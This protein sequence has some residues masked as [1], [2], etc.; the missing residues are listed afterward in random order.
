ML[1]CLLTDTKLEEISLTG[2]D[3]F[4]GVSILLLTLLL[5]L[6]ALVNNDKKS[7]M[8]SAAV[9]TVS[10][11]LSSRKLMPLHG[12]VPIIG[13]KAN[14]VSLIPLLLFSVMSPFLLFHH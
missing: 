4:S 9:T 5:F 2:I 11:L 3:I 13:T 6:C 14:F 7:L 1:S 10:S 8:K 12:G